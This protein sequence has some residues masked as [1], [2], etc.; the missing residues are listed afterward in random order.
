MLPEHYTT[1]SDL[2]SKV[3]RTVKVIG[4]ITK[5]SPD[6]RRLNLESWD[7]KI[8][9]L[10]LP[11]QVSKIRFSLLTFPH[12]CLLQFP[13]QMKDFLNGAGNASGVKTV[14]LHDYQHGGTT[15]PTKRL[16]G[17]HTIGTRNTFV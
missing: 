15:S 11:S 17:K 14:K 6:K 13:G 8:I 3:G 9:F 4:E 10:I 12:M 1:A 7:R 5:I 16:Y 2:P